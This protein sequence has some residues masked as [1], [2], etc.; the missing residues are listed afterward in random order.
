MSH[1]VASALATPGITAMASMAVASAILPSAR[2]APGTLLDLLE[3]G[4]DSRECADGRPRGVPHRTRGGELDRAP[5]AGPALWR[6]REAGDLRARV[7]DAGLRRPCCLARRRLP[8]LVW[9]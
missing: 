8:R 2:I 9:K 3:S 5:L 4:N 7:H 1:G 6:S